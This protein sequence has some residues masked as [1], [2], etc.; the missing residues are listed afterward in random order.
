MRGKRS[1][2]GGRWARPL[3]WGRHRAQHQAASVRLF[4]SLARVQDDGAAGENVPP[5]EMT[6]SQPLTPSAL[7]RTPMLQATSE[8]R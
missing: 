3:T 1:V 8:T 7:A 6:R 2:V 5:Q 4:T